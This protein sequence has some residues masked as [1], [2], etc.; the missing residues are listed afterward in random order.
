[1]PLVFDVPRSL[2]LPLAGPS[3]DPLVQ[4]PVSF[5]PLAGTAVILWALARGGRAVADAAGGRSLLR[6]LHGMKVA[7]PYAAL[8]FG[9]SFAVHARLAL[10]GNPGPTVH[11]EPIGALLWPMV[12]AATAGFAGGVR[13]SAP[14]SGAT[15]QARIRAALAGGW[16]MLWL[17]LSLSFVGLLGVAVARPD[18][19]RDF[20]AGA[21]SSGALQGAVLLGL[22]FLVTP[23]MAAW[24][25]VPALGGCTGVSGA[26]SACFLSYSHFADLGTVL[27]GLAAS[28]G[29]IR[30]P[31]P[32]GWYFL[33]LL[34]P[35]VAT[36]AGGA[37]AARRGSASNRTQ[38]A[39]LGAGSGVVFAALTG[40]AILLAQLALGARGAVPGFFSPGTLRVGPHLISGV[41]VAAAWG[42]VGG[43]LGGL[44]AFARAPRATTSP[45]P[46][47][48]EKWAP[49]AP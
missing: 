36:V 33:F 12:L 22:T 15:W 49:E 10:R 34:A 27:D 29:S 25:L 3:L 24:I 32:P 42:V 45:D 18:E 30:A 35:V 47:R 2:F 4:V 14:Y 39:A 40:L 46:D 6:G 48:G 44:I 8:T 11:P 28:S 7:L 26:F 13:S 41:L 17:G 1:V 23:N 19:T 16:R 37:T 9:L 20:V 5:A 38:S 21:F 43:A 31:S